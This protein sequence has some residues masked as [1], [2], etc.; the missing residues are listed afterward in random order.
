MKPGPGSSDPFVTVEGAL[1][2]HGP[3]GGTLDG[4]MGPGSTLTSPRE[5]PSGGHV[6]LLL[7]SPVLPVA[8]SPAAGGWG[9][10]LHSGDRRKEGGWSGAV[11]ENTV[12]GKQPPLFLQ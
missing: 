10:G 8:T 11:R 5:S 12:Q 2:P 3:G 6:T 9:E 7:S 4:E 1:V